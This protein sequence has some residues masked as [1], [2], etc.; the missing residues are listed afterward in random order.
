MIDISSTGMSASSKMQAKRSVNIIQRFAND[1]PSMASCTKCQCKFVTPSTLKHDLAGAK[2]YLR[3]K[4]H[5]HE[6][7]EEPVTRD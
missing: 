3:E 1:V 5:L 2:L 6:C 4:F 7:G